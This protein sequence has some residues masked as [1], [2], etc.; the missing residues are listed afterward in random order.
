MSLLL[1]CFYSTCYPSLLLCKASVKSCLA[2]QLCLNKGCHFLVNY[3]WFF[4]IFQ[5]FY[6]NLMKDEIPMILRLKHCKLVKKSQWLNP[7]MKVIAFSIKGLN[8]CLILLILMNKMLFLWS[9]VAQ[10]F[11]LIFNFWELSNKGNEGEESHILLQGVW[12]VKMV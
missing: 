6:K 5:F 11:F 2:Y 9:L 1:P 7:Y 3:L 4:L 10:F 12:G 8:E